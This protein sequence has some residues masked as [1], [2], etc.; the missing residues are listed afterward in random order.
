MVGLPEQA[1]HFGQCLLAVAEHRHIDRHILIYLRGIDV[2]VDLLGSRGVRAQLTGD[3]VVEAHAHSYQQVALL[4]LD[5]GGVGA[6]HAEHAHI[7]RVI[8]GERREAE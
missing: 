3:A 2:K 6:V 7:K 4:R 8:A 1:C 5:I